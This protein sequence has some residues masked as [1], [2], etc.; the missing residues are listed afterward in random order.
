MAITLAQIQEAKEKINKV[1]EAT[2]KINTILVKVEE[3]IFEDVV[4]SAIQKSDLLTKYNIAKA[5]LLT[6]IN[7]LL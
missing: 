4:L 7:K 1:Q 3:G 6:A 2:S 5:E